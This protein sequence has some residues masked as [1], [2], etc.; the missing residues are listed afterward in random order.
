MSENLPQPSPPRQESFPVELIDKFLINQAE[1]IKLQHK[2]LDIRAQSETNQHEY[3]KELLK[4]QATDLEDDR[5][6]R[7]DEST[8]LKY[9]I[10][11]IIVILVFL[12]CFM[13]Y[14]GKESIALEIVKAL[15]YLIAGAL[16]GLGYAKVKGTPAKD[17][18][19]G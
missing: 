19:D 7:G 8:K 9:F 16:G 6:F 14:I 4:T 18:A 10:L 11:A 5:T 13:V 1:Q 12:I 3:A 15:I 17:P 2:E